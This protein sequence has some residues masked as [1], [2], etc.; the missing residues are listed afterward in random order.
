MTWIRELITVVTVFLIAINQIYVVFSNQHKSE[1]L[2][3][4]KYYEITT[5]SHDQLHKIDDY[6]NPI[7]PTNGMLKFDAFGRV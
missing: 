1:L 6:D 5:I 4:L 2:K 7:Y 3:R